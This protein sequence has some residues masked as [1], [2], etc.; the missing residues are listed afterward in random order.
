MIINQINQE[1]ENAKNICLASHLN[2][3]GDNLGSI[4]GL[5]KLLTNKSKNVNLII[6][7]EVPD[8]LKFLPNLDKSIK[9]SEIKE[10]PD[11]FIV[12]DCADIGRVSNGVREIFEKT[13]STINIDHH[14]TNTKFADINL[15]DTK[16]PATG[17]LLFTLLDNLDYE[18][19]KEIA[20]CL[21]AA[22][23]SDTGSFK[24]DSTR[25]ETFMAAAKLLEYGIN[26]N[27]IAINLYQKRSIGKTKLLMNAMDTLE[28]YENNKIALVYVD[29]EMIKNANAKKMDSEGIVEFIRDIDDVEIA[30]FMK[31]K[32]K[33]IKLSIRTKSYAN[34][35]NI[36]EKFDGGGHIRAAGASMKLDFENQKKLLIK[37]AMDE[38]N[39]RNNSNK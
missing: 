8:N 30:L 22:I 7:D 23:S 17:E 11:L 13:K 38:L 6:D 27:D 5:Y 36:A 24:Y 34:A 31:I 21:Y 28:F 3:D 10:N 20:T 12:L 14:L 33:S 1:I 19:D 35:I 18:L 9:S 26:V 29:D 37:Y 4:L 15:V 16:S 32:Q 25:K 2:P 39:E